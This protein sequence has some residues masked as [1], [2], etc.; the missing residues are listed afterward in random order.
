MISFGSQNQASVVL[1]RGESAL[2]CFFDVKDNDIQ[3]VG[4]NNGDDVTHGDSIEIYFDFK[5]DAA[6][7]PQTDDMREAPSITIISELTTRGAKV[8]VYDPEAYIMAKT[9]LSKIPSELISYEDDMW[10]PLKNA[11]ALVLITEWK[12]FRQPNFDKIKELLKTPIIFDGRNQY[13]I[14]L[15][16][17]KNIEYFCIGRNIQK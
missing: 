16:K 10:S 15:M 11:D 1:Y 12:Q 2:F 6:G 13:D 5:N 7:K 4:N 14:S 3:T 8:K 17:E 9:Y